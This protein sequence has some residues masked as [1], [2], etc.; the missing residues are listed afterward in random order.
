MEY[1]QNILIGN[2]VDEKKL[3]EDLKDVLYSYDDF[4]KDMIKDVAK[5]SN[6]ILKTIDPEELE[7]IEVTQEELND[8]KIILK[9]EDPDKTMEDLIISYKAYKYLTKR[10]S[11]L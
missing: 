4:V 7:K 9:D 10:K 5:D 11:D 6:E 2:E 1:M 8:I 3:V